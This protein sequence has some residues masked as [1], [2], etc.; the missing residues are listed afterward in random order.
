MV[1]LRLDD[2]YYMVARI[3]SEQNAQRPAS[4]TFSHFVEVCGMLTIY[5]RDKKR[6]QFT[7]ED[8]ICKALG[9]F[10]PLLAKFR[11]RSIEDLI[12][13]KYPGV[14]P[15]CRRKPHVDSICKV[16]R[17]TQQTVD[18]EELRKFYKRNKSKRPV[19]LDE[20]MALFQEI[21]PR[22]KTDEKGRNTLGLL[23]ELGELAEAIRVYDVHPK[24]FA[25]EIADVFSY[26]MGVANRYD[27]TLQE[28]GKRF[29]LEK[30]F[31]KRYPG[32]CVQCGYEICICPAIP[33]ATIGRMAKELDL[34]KDDDLFRLELE[35]L[36]S[37]ARE[38]SKKVLEIVGGYPSLI[39]KFPFDRGEANKALV[40]FCLNLAE[41]IHEKDPP[42][43][44]TLRSAALRVGNNV[45]PPG[46]REHVNYH[47]EI[48][49]SLRRAGEISDTPNEAGASKVMSLVDNLGKMLVK[50]KILM[51][52]SSPYKDEE[53][54]RTETEAKAA[55]DS[56]GRSKRRDY[57]N[58]KY[59]PSGGVDDLRKA[60]LEE[61]RFDIIHLAGHGTKSGYLFNDQVGNSVRTS[62]AALR[63]WL[64]GKKV[65]CFIINA[66]DALK[67]VNESLGP[68]TVGMTGVVTDRAAIEFTRGFYDAIG[69]GKTIDV[70]ISEGK[71]AVALKGYESE[72]PLT[73]L[74]AQ[75]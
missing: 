64:R 37:K 63:N 72:L 24:Y 15:Y 35:S 28:E 71:H 45:T 5:D 32:L 8:A 49:D 54:L 34:L 66:C 22:Q 41:A 11:V 73:I 30:A 62:M 43:S 68:I 23:E 14:C 27:L 19:G 70:A 75:R 60:L 51:I 55:Q 7:I 74:P 18:H 40:L 3:Y 67:E 48:V 42:L 52:S 6:E 44:Q 25:G 39:G 29:S 59:I 21:Y 4:A 57:I 31:I 20:W 65:E 56:I 9:W 33:E 1:T 13:R 61:E 50:T 47:E 10:F 46:A 17:G 53:L 58:I 38:T 16:I 69:A 12:F 26:I 36:H 2:L